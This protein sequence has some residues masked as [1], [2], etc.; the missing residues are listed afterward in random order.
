METANNPITAYILKIIFENSR[1]IDV[2]L[3]ILNYIIKE[4]NG[5]LFFL[6]SEQAHQK[7]EKGFLISA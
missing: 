3:R 4:N 1:N 6:V 5:L 2:T 7:S